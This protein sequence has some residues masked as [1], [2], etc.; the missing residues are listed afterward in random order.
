MRKRKVGSITLGE[1]ATVRRSAYIENLHN[2][3][4]LHELLLG[5]MHRFSTLAGYVR[6]VIRTRFTGRDR[7]SV[8][9]V[10]RGCQPP[11]ERR[12]YKIVRY[13]NTGTT[14][15]SHIIYHGISG[16]TLAIIVPSRSYDRGWKSTRQQCGQKIAESRIKLQKRLGFEEFTL[17]ATY[18]R[19]G[20]ASD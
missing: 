7:R 9:I 15:P 20:L 6:N 13:G 16:I 8:V 10:D 12:S 3:Y 18:V 4:C 19:R 5:M 17:Y 14:P 2:T 1:A 11:F